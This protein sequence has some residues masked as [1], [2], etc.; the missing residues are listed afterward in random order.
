MKINLDSYVVVQLT[1]AGVSHLMASH[2]AVNDCT[3]SMGKVKGRATLRCQ[4]WEF[5]NIFGEKTEMCQELFDVVIELVDDLSTI[6]ES[7]EEDR[8]PATPVVY[9]GATTKSRIAQW[10]GVGVTKS[11][12]HMIVVTDTFDNSDHPVYAYS[13]AECLQR[14]SSQDT[15]DTQ[16]ITEVYDLRMD[17]ETQ[18]NQR[19]AYN[20][21][22]GVPYGKEKK[23]DA[24]A[25]EAGERVGKSFDE[26]L[27]AFGEGLAGQRKATQPRDIAGFIIPVDQ[28]K[29]YE[30]E[31]LKDFNDPD[32]A[33]SAAYVV[34]KAPHADDTGEPHKS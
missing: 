17:K 14:V 30:G 12:T 23:A 33:T 24:S 21:P 18:L 13:D 28:D 20:V 5:M 10:F 9:S 26:A 16:H 31:D 2:S 15:G 8:S 22:K 7:I 1:E 34:G 3:L 11:A 29:G 4:L 19:R 32:T 27:K 6:G 25:A